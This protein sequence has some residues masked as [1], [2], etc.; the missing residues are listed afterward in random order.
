MLR[1]QAP[2]SP[3][4]AAGWEFL[5]LLITTYEAARSSHPAADREALL[6]IMRLKG[7]NAQELEALVGERSARA[8]LAG[9]ERL[10]A[11]GLRAIRSEWGVPVGVLL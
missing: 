3:E 1:S 6:Q 5:G 10:P 8:V 2:P 4:V 11:D 9:R 7:K